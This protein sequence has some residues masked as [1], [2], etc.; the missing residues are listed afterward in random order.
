MIKFLNRA[1]PGI[2]SYLLK[3]LVHP[4]TLHV[5]VRLSTHVVGVV[6]LVILL[7]APLLALPPEIDLWLVPVVDEPRPRRLRIVV[8]VGLPRR[9]SAP[10][11][12][13][14]SSSP[15]AALV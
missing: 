7:S 13:I 11:Y 12:D 8:L 9:S 2:F 6:L 1:L 15:G 5:A 10:T 4:V 3:A 14:A